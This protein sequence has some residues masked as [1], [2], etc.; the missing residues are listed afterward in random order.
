MPSPRP[1][2]P[3]SPSAPAELPSLSPP[4]MRRLLR[5]YLAE[6]RAEQDI[7]TEAVIP[8][9]TRAQGI[10]E[11]Q[12]SGVVSGLDA[13]QMLA[14]EVGLEV[15]RHVSDGSSV[16][17]GTPLLTLRGDA[18]RILSVERTLVNLVMHLSGVAT[19]TARMVRAVREV[20]PRF[21]VLA[22]R[23]TLPGL[24]DLEKRAVVHGGGH[25]HRRDLASAILVKNNHLALVPLREAV[26][27]AR[28]RAGR[29]RELMVEV[30][31]LP[32]AREA[33][34]AGA[35]RILLDNLSPAGA[36][37]L[38]RA[39]EREGLRD[40]VLLEVTGGVSHATVREYART[41]ADMAS[42]GRL[43]H[44]ARALSVHLVVSPL[45]PTPRAGAASARP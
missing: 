38:I 5:S 23:K 17:R 16:R 35:H 11:A 42:A 34:R 41:G 4:R 29:S 7:T 10:L 2:A 30:R 25:P 24:R 20:D 9:R 37:Q 14:E 12:E 15:I 33:I 21:Q 28:R 43:T 26:R 27:R 39:L 3:R 1:T 40:R 22:T 32:E 45:P 19:E 6:D 13:A 18:R 36:R 44:S 8:P 31:S